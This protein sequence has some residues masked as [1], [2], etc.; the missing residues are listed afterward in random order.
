MDSQNPFVPNVHFELLRICDLVSSQEYQRSLSEQHIARAVEEFDLHQIN[1]VKVSRR[2]NTNYVFDGQ[3]TAEIVAE[4]SGS[5]ETPVWCMIYDDLTYEHEADIFANQQKYTKTL[6]PFEIFQANLEAKN[7][8]Q[9]M[10]RDLV[11]SYKMKIGKTSA[12]GTIT[13]VSTLESIYTKHGFHVLD[14]TLKLSVI[15]W[16]GEKGSFS[17][18]MLNAIAKLVITYGKTLNDATFK[19]RV[20]EIPLKQL[21]RMAKERRPGCMGYAEALVITYN[22]RRK[23]FAN[24]LHIQKLYSAV[25]ASSYQDDDNDPETYS[26]EDSG[27]SAKE[28][29][30]EQTIFEDSE[31]PFSTPSSPY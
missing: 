17:S 24:Y 1:P 8:D 14:R 6:S 29:F 21:T 30:E 11:E 5:R 9:L 12:A 20:G 18:N 3:H 4:K 22:G 7:N 19:E 15:T 23:N 25:P 28:E 27:E 26:S 10:I 13:A 16:E 2:N 31:L